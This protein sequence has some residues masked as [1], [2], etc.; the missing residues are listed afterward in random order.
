MQTLYCSNIMLY[1]IRAPIALAFFYTFSF[2]FEYTGR[3]SVA[4]YESIVVSAV[5]STEYQAGNGV[6]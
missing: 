6:P 4:T 1:N 2:A 3:P 5:H